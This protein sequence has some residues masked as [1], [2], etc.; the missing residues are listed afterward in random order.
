MARRR[1]WAHNYLA[2]RDALKCVPRHLVGRADS[3]LIALVHTGLIATYK[4]GAC[5]YLVPER[6]RE[7]EARVLAFVRRM[8][9]ETNW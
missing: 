4:K 6:K 1:N 8:R 3:A 2:R 7:I 5:V 9:L